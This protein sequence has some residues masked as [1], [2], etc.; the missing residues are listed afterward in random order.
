MFLGAVFRCPSSFHLL[1][2]ESIQQHGHGLNDLGDKFLSADGSISPEVMGD[3]LHPTEKGYGIW[4]DAIQPF[5][6]KF[7][8]S[9][10]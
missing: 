7:V 4:A 10:N 3:F 6:D 8:F 9:G 1:H 5:V 2:P